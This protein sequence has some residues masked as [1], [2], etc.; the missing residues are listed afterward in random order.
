MDRL[1][2]YN[3]TLADVLQMDQEERED[4]VQDRAARR[5]NARGEAAPQATTQGKVTKTKRNV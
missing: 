3:L 5:K 2:G 1:G 4:W